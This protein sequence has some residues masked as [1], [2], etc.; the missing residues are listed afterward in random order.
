MIEEM[1]IPIKV[2]TFLNQIIMGLGLNHYDLSSMNP[3]LSLFEESYVRAK[4]MLTFVNS[5]E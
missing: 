5:M 1:I 4:L 2:C 3:I